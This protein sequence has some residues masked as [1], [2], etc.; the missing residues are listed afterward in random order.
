MMNVTKRFLTAKECSTHITTHVGLGD[1]ENGLVAIIRIR[2]IL[3]RAISEAS[4][5]VI[6]SI[7]QAGDTPT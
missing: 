3:P 5:R 1:L 4:L 2:F 7:R 6:D